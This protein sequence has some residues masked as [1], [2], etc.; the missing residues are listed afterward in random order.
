MKDKE[1][2]SIINMNNKIEQNIINQEAKQSE[3]NIMV[4]SKKINPFIEIIDSSRLDDNIININ[5]KNKDLYNIEK[6]TIENKEITNNNISNSE[7]NNNINEEPMTFNPNKDNNSIKNLYKEEKKDLLT[8][9]NDEDNYKVEN[10]FLI[11]NNINSNQIILKEDNLNIEEIIAILKKLIDKMKYNFNKNSNKK[12]DIMNSNLLVNKIIEIKNDVIKIFD[13]IIEEET[14]KRNK[15]DFNNINYS[16]NIYNKNILNSKYD[17]YSNK[18][19]LNRKINEIEEI[20]NTYKTEIINLKKRI[21]HIEQE[22]NNLKNIIQNSQN[23]FEDLIYKNR[24]LSNKL[25]KYKSLYEEKKD[26]K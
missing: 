16:N 4:Q 9:N 19:D 11:N 14:L 8:F 20:E 5:S 2:E 12:Y 10:N 21:I 6:E 1:I 23:L 17:F 13:N 24:L 22:N 18:L 25:I 15:V 3:K 26:N 7:I